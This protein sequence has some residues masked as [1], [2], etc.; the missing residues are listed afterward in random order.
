[1]QQIK[2]EMCTRKNED[3]KHR[4][5]LSRYDGKGNLSTSILSTYLCSN[6]WIN[7]VCRWT[8]SW[9]SSITLVT[10]GHNE[11][12]I[13]HFVD[14]LISTW[15]GICRRVS[16]WTLELAEKATLHATFARWCQ[17]NGSSRRRRGLWRGTASTT[18]N[19]F[20]Y[21]RALCR[22]RWLSRRFWNAILCHF[23]P[24]FVNVLLF[25]EVS[26]KWD[27]L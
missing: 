4:Q 8:R 14:G 27:L 21:R 17:R 12:G 23:H 7:G 2:C 5:A 22:R 24:S 11:I 16:E 19:S 18:S 1:M 9:R 10:C 15:G 13:I 20:P 25:S 26:C 3:H 6:I